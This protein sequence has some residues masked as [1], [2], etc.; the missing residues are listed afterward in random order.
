M[1]LKICN[2]PL[3]LKKLIEGILVP[4]KLYVT[5]LKLVGS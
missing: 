2:G 5:S 3:N 1:L 4:L